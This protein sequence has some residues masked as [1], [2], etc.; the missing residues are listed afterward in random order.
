MW[1]RILADWD[2]R[3]DRNQILSF[4]DD[5]GILAD[6]DLRSDRNMSGCLRGLF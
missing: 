5:R 4:K 1:R 6:W 2:L 3:S